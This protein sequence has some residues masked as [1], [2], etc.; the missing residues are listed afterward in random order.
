MSNDTPYVK[1]ISFKSEITKD[2]KKVRFVDYIAPDGTKLRYS[3]GQ[4]SVRV[5]GQF[6][7]DFGVTNKR[8]IRRKKPQDMDDLEFIERT[9]LQ[10][11]Q[12]DVDE[13]TTPKELH[14]KIVEG[15]IEFIKGRV[16]EDYCKREKRN[17]KL[18]LY[19]FRNL[20]IAKLTY[21]VVDDILSHIQ[22]EQSI[23]QRN[24][25]KGTYK[26][27]MDFA[28]QRGY[29]DATL[30]IFT[31]IKNTSRPEDDYAN[32]F[33]FES[34][35]EVAKEHHTVSRLIEMAETPTQ[36]LLLILLASTGARISEVLALKWSDLNQDK[37]RDVVELNLLNLKKN[38][39]NNSKSTYRLFDVNINTYNQILL[40]KS[41]IELEYKNFYKK[42]QASKYHFKKRHVEMF[43][44]GYNF[45]D[46]NM[47]ASSYANIATYSCA[48]KWYRNIWERTYDKYIEHEVPFP[49]PRN[50]SGYTFHCFR[51]YYITAFRENI[52][53][54]YTKS[55]H[56]TLQQ[57]VGH[58]IGS[59][60]TDKMYTHWKKENVTA[61]KMNSKIDLGFSI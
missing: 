26:R 60:M 10:L 44:D 14:K 48:R 35:G 16:S 42:Y 4:N 47:I 57:L 3:P 45:E 58:E 24:M 33:Y 25:Q 6:E 13:V 21:A 18:M 50:V 9:Y 22:D 41:E 1:T 8:D 30:N 34:A 56:E 43:R 40:L 59:T 27:I 61:R 49:H 37:T 52:G 11:K 51:R 17:G 28:I 20:D 38:Y 2:K 32:K 36:K 54:E 12:N 31:T 15:Y 55:H 5:I 39:K 29:I 23:Y 46:R 53:E 7:T 19:Y